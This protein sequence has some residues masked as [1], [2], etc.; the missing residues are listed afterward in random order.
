MVTKYRASSPGDELDGRTRSRGNASWITAG[1]V[2]AIAA[3]VSANIVLAR[4]LQPDQMGLYILASSLAFVASIVARLGTAQLVPR[5]VGDALKA[6]DYPSATR[7]AV[8]CHLVAGT[9][10]TIWAGLL[11]SSL[12]QLA[13]ASLHFPNN[14]EIR[15]A[16]AVWILSEAVRPVTSECFRSFGRVDLATASGEPLR[17]IALLLTFLA[18]P[19]AAKGGSAWHPIAASALV[20]L[21]ISVMSLLGLIAYV[22][23]AEAM[24]RSPALGRRRAVTYSALVRDGLP[25]LVTSGC[26]LVVQQAD[27]WVVAASFSNVD[28]VRYGLALK[29]AVIFDI[30]VSVVN[31]AILPGLSGRKRLTRENRGLVLRGSAGITSSICLGMLVLLAT[32]GSHVVEGLYG[33]SYTN[34]VGLAVVLG[35]SQLA[36]AATGVA[37]IVLTLEGRG[38]AVMMI[39]ILA[40]VGMLVATLAAAR[41]GSIHMVAGSSVL[42]MA[43]YGS[44]LTFVCWKLTG[45]STAATFKRRAVL[46]AYGSLVRTES[47]RGD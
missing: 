13:L 32:L 18:W 46:A 7:S 28:L 22:Q 21:L 4:R 27:L 44:S 8:R 41:S 3:L 26:L 47:P 29:I 11:V 36:N 2:T 1:R 5:Y 19:F 16:L 37:P 24:S 30:P 31:S 35:L 25:L 10:A 33:A 12:G 43:A 42:A 6:N 17:N 20:S 14:I 15:A 9:S 23:N 34:V 38:S 39:S 45:L 40:A